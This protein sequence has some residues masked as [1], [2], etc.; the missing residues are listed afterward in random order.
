MAATEEF[1]EMIS[2]IV[3]KYSVAQ[4]I[5]PI[6]LIDSFIQ[7]AVLC[8]VDKIWHNQRSN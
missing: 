1:I 2:T 4:S 8:A 3:Y 5:V 7:I 6:V